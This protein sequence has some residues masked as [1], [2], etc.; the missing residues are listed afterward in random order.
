MIRQMP[1]SSHWSYVSMTS[2]S[3]VTLN[4]LL[5]EDFGS[6]SSACLEEK[7]KARCSMEVL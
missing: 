7:N 6:S 1:S 2:C 4:G 3:T 5:T